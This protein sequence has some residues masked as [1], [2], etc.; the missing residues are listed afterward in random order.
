MGSS[1]KI[2]SGFAWTT[3]QTI[4]NGIY[5]FVSVPL[6]LAYFGKSNYG[7]IGL[8]M[9]INV[10][11]R[12][13]DLGFN[14]TSVRYF[15][16]WCAKKNYG[17]VRKLF[18]T[19]LTFYGS[20]G[21]INSLVLVVVSFFSSQIFG[22]ASDQDVVLKHL[23]YI[24]AISAFIGWYTS[25]FNQI[26]QGNE[27]VGWVQKFVFIPKCVQILILVLTLTCKFSIELYYGLTVFS[28]FLTLPIIVW[29]IRKVCP[30]ISFKPGFDN[31][32]FKEMLP[33]SLQVFSF[34]F[35]QFSA[36]YLRPVILGIRGNIESVAD[37]RILNGI[38]SI[39]IMLGGMFIGIIMPSASKVVAMNDIELQNR[40]AYQG[41]KYLS[42]F[43]CLVS[44]GMMSISRDLLLA[45]VGPEYLHLLVWLNLWLVMTAVGSHIQCM[46][47]LILSGTKISGV[48]IPTITAAIVTIVSCWFLTPYFQ[49]GGAVI[50][51]SLFSL[52]L[53]AYYYLYYYQK[54]M[55]K[56]SWKL[57][58]RSF[59][60]SFLLGF[61]LS[62]GCIYMPIELGKWGTLFC[63][64]IIFA[65][66]YLAVSYALLRKEDR[67]FLFG[68]VKKQ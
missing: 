51:Y 30:Y 44:F 47:S 67:K 39:V 17:M 32:I 1:K 22:V 23:F 59:M 46:S 21:L 36:N 68:L 25:V 50:A 41:T 11:L 57:F 6:L 9:S 65:I 12:M 48:T 55:H 35:F 62:I 28:A 60:P 31:N 4:I 66:M 5:G 2:A 64:G 18:S 37:F 42:I 27:Y 52:I 40:I 45:Y 34:G 15:A 58:S 3:L 38:V 7:L 53:V 43:L 29:K 54:K 24:L 49:V 56:D 33:Y 10:Y 13:M 61:V 8:A 16:N 26:L 19:N 14:N 63:K 20:L